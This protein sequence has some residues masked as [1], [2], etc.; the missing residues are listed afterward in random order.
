LTIACILR[1][2]AK[3]ALQ[4]RKF[5]QQGISLAYM[6]S[7]AM[8]TVRVTTNGATVNSVAVAKSTQTPSA[9]HDPIRVMQ[10]LRTAL[11]AMSVYPWPTSIQSGHSRGDSSGTGKLQNRQKQWRKP[12]HVHARANME[13]WATHEIKQQSKVA[14]LRKFSNPMFGSSSNPKHHSWESCLTRALSRHTLN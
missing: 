1:A 10:S 11:L 6:I 2:V 7:N 8:M 4:L 12:P 3:P 14:K 5:S 9:P 13:G